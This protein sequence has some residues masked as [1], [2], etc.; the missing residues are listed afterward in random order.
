MY[1]INIRV[2]RSHKSGSLFSHA[3]D[4]KRKMVV[5]FSFLLIPFAYDSNN[6]FICSFVLAAAKPW[7]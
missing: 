3:T 1:N 2:D 5:S 4:E 6:L 7:M